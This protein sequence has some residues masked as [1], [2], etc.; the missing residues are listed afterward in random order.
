MVEVSRIGLD[1]AKS[2]IQVGG[3]GFCRSAT[4]PRWHGR[5]RNGPSDKQPT[6]EIFT[7]KSSEGSQDGC[8]SLLAL[9]SGCEGLCSRPILTEI[10]A[11]FPRS[12]LAHAPVLIPV[13]GRIRRVT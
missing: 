3:V 4:L 5:V 9:S 11:H 6:L 12:S 1:I 10:V 13:E 8:A 7:V 2:V